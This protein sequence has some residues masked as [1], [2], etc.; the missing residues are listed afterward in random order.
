[1]NK[2]SGIFGGT[3]DPVH[4][5]HVECVKYLLNNS[6]LDEIIIMPSGIPPHKN[7]N[8][9]T[10]IDHR[11]KMLEIVFQNIAYV[12]N[13]ECIDE[14]CFTYFTLKTLK[15]SNKNCDIFFILGEDN[16]Y[17]INKWKNYKELINEN[18]FILMKRG[19]FD[20]YHKDCSFLT[21]Q[22]F[23]KLTANTIST[24]Q[25]SISSSLLRN[26]IKNKNDNINLY[27]EPKVIE[28]IKKNDLYN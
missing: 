1:M 2:K 14:P 24:P 28:Y 13:L 19:G 18:N 7:I 9:I 26:M 4:I 6:F 10:P 22:E 25:I 21:M 12:S 15:E 20:V 17:S 3:F 5:G 27:I 23:N 11:L 16:L 8:N